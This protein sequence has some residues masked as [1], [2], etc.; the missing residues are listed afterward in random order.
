MPDLAVADLGAGDSAAVASEVEGSVVALEADDLA[1]VVSEAVALEVVD[2]AEVEVCSEAGELG[3]VT[4]AEA[5]SEASASL[6]VISEP[7]GIGA[8]VVVRAVSGKV[9]TLLV[10]ARTSSRETVEWS[11]DRKTVRTGAVRISK[12]VRTPPCQ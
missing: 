1:V 8:P 7:D 4:L 11:K 12:T 5:V 6:A 2:L 9:E 3:E 10:P